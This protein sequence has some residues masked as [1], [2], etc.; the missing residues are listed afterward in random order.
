MSQQT[1]ENDQAVLVLASASPRRRELLTAAGYAFE[2][3][4]ANLHEPDHAGD[5]VSPMALAEALSFFKA[6]NVADALPRGVVLGADTIVALGEEVY[7]KPDDVDDA[8]RILMQLT[9]HPHQVVTGVTLL[10]A[11]T[12]RREITHE[13]TQVTMTPMS[14]DQLDAY[15]ASG[16]WAGK[17]GAYG[18]QDHDDAF[19][20]R[21]DGSF[22]NVVGLP[23]E[24]LADMLARWG[25]E[26]RPA[27][28]C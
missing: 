23:M 28:E 13:V 20:Q 27:T 15:L 4:P 24:L 16:L 3:V 18:I 12:G 10:D 1:V 11:A 6:R 5:H 26:P 21:L 9:H 7:G 2:V 8:R 25:V 22:S 14:P 17:A 19:V